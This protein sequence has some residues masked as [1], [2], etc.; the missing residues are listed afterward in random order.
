MIQVDL[1]TGFLG[2]GKTTFIKQYARKLMEA[3]LNIGI[4]LNDYGAVNVDRM[5]LSDLSG[6]QCDLDMVAGGCDADCHR[7]RFKTKLISMGM[8]GYDRVLIEPSGIFDM[9]E[10]F[11]VLKEEP[12]DRWYQPGNVIA[13]VEAGLSDSLSETSDYFLASQIAHAGMVIFSK[14][15]EAAPEE[16]LGTTEHLNRALHHVQCHRTFCGK[17]ILQKNWEDLTEEDWEAITSC[18]YKNESYVKLTVNKENAFSTLYYMNVHKELPQLTA[19]LK[20]MM[21]DPACGS[22]MRIKGF[23]PDPEGGFY[24]VN[25]TREKARIHHVETGQE[26]FIVIGE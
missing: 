4:L 1:I 16:I 11:D 8:Q 13:I 9:D 12:L 2:S 22:I 10:F 14:V 6:Q 24:E 17:E 26:I 19:L 23:L 20:V 18:G 3:G 21:S 25:V 7:R 15:Q 5:L